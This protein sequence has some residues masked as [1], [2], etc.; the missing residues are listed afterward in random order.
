MILSQAQQH[1]NEK[2]RIKSSVEE[3]FSSFRKVLDASGATTVLYIVTSSIIISL[4]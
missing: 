2:M 1:E 3:Y 4:S